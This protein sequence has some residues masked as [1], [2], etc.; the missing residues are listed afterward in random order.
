M[1]I[2]EIIELGVLGALLLFS[3]AACGDDSI[4]PAP[5]DGAADTA[6]LAK[7]SDAAPANTTKNEDAGD[8]AFE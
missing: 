5:I 2:I 1:N 8:A 4:D 6:T 7:S 3:V